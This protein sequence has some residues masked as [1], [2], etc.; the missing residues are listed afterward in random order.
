MNTDLESVIH[1]NPSLN[2]ILFDEKTKVLNCQKIDLLNVK[3]VKVKCF[4][5]D[6]NISS[7]DFK[8]TVENTFDNQRH[9]PSIFKVE[10][11]KSQLNSAKLENSID[12]VV[13]SNS[14]DG[15]TSQVNS[16]KLENSINGVVLRNS[17]D[18]VVL[19]NSID[20]ET[21]QVN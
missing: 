21:S 4:V 16:A 8:S 11:E 12:G 7:V 5:S 10:G 6:F 15:E 20:G 19:R 13:L 3:L 17:I 1:F 18:G 9:L 14:I 2:T